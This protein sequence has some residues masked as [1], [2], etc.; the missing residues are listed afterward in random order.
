[1]PS[2]AMSWVAAITLSTTI[3]AIKIGIDATPAIAI[4][5]STTTP[6]SCIG[7]IHDRRRPMRGHHLRSTIGAHANFSAHGAA[8]SEVSPISPSE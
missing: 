1:M 5:A 4:A 3:D 2:V 7:K 8:S 6:A